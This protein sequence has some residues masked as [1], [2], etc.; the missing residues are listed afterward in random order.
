MSEREIQKIVNT[1]RKNA[2][3][4]SSNAAQNTAFLKRVGILTKGG[5]PSK[6]YLKICTPTGQV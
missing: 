3:K 5:N 1:I 2:K 6:A 4:S